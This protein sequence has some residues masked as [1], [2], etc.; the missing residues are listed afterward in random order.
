[1]L[2]ATTLRGET[3]L[4]SALRMVH[5][6]SRQSQ[7]TLPVICAHSPRWIAAQPERFRRCANP[8]AP[9]G[10]H[11]ATSARV[12]ASGSETA[13]AQEESVELPPT[14]NSLVK[15]CRN[16]ADRDR[17]D[18]YLQGAKPVKVRGWA[19]SVRDH[20]KVSFVSLVDGSMSADNHLQIVLSPQLR[21]E[22]GSRLSPGAS[23]E[24]EGALCEVRKKDGR[25]SGGDD[26]EL[27]ATSARVVAV[28]DSASYPVPL[29][30]ENNPTETLRAHAHLRSRDMRHAALLRSRD[31]L[32]RGLA[33]YFARNEFIKVTTPII[34]SS[35]CEGAGE[36]FQIV[37]DSDLKKVDQPKAGA[38]EI[39]PA[40]NGMDHEHSTNA[41]TS[42]PTTS[43]NQLQAFWSGQPAYLSVSAQLH[44]EAIMHG[45]NR[46]WTLS[47]AF[48]AE[49]SATN[50]HLAEFWMAE[51]EMVTSDDPQVALEEVMTIVEGS[52]KASA[53]ALFG[54]EWREPATLFLGGEGDE[55]ADFL[56]GAPPAREFRN[57]SW[58]VW[59]EKQKIKELSLSRP[60]SA[61][62][63]IP[64]DRPWT[65]MTYSQAI[66]QLRQIHESAGFRTEPIAG[67][68]LATEHE[69][70]LAEDG[71]VFITHY[72]A[73]SK[74]FYMRASAGAPSSDQGGSEGYTGPTVDCFDLLV[75][76]MGELVGGSLRE[77]RPEVIQEKLSS[78]G[79][80]EKAKKQMEWYASDLRRFGTAPHGGFGLGMERLLS[81]LTDTSNLKDCVTF[82]RV[83]GRVRY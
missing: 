60:P 76:G 39:S 11:F 82:P 83:K 46:I 22:L 1:M 4:M 81:W 58:D 36:V 79:W 34:T 12:S 45:L 77:T 14:L 72:P 6:S 35:D 23:L 13:R 33:D 47:P 32:E 65:R 38:A 41:E 51:V 49:G 66:T 57:L 80:S 61:L 75:P 44:L 50:R 3:A 54:A 73:H 10:R 31:C 63:E 55:D 42:Q 17:G 43:D 30:G 67:Q 19:R 7:H 2:R 68:P 16:D 62:D 78:L 18:S 69:A 52:V 24:I 37:A 71:P 21:E 70:A 27:R 9:H 56:I 25:A 48:R 20:R 28:C 15:A 74:P 59:E 40:E 5:T 64:F 26:V 53:L 8:S 29:Q